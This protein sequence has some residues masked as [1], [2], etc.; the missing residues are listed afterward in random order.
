MLK[1]LFYLFGILAILFVLAEIAGSLILAGYDAGL[2]E[3]R[4]RRTAV[5]DRLEAKRRAEETLG[6][7]YAPHP[8]IGLVKRQLPGQAGLGSDA[9]IESILAHHRP[10]DYNVLLLGGSTAASIQQDGLEYMTRS[11]SALPWVRD[12]NVN[13]FNGSMPQAKQPQQL[14]ALT[15]LLSLGAKVDM[16]IN[17]D[18]FNE[19]ALTPVA[20]P[21]SSLFYPVGW[22]QTTAAD[23]DLQLSLLGKLR[24][25]EEFQERFARFFSVLGALPSRT[26]NALWLVIHDRSE[27]NAQEVLRK[28]SEARRATEDAD[29]V[30]YRPDVEGE[31]ITRVLADHWAR[32]SKLMADFALSQ[33]ILYIHVLQPSAFTP[34]APTR[35]AHGA[36][37]YAVWASRGYRSM[38][39]HADALQRMGVV[40]LDAS[41]LFAPSGYGT[42][43][44]GCCT[45]TD[46]GAQMLIREIVGTLGSLD[47]QEMMA[48]SYEEYLSRFV[49]TTLLPNAGLP[50]LQ[51]GG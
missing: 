45:L 5:M 49:D 40:F 7:E 28:L 21:Y 29:T 37:P 4:A 2:D 11:L 30:G 32:S 15:Y 12:R 51:E 41:A 8:Y 38:V 36:S 18:G 44:Q 22:S 47:G 17:I 16:V 14:Q 48:H 13:V 3:V 42:Y 33:G 9:W 35:A 39:D 23:S 26:V 27:K 10:G 34:G 46:E 43:M 19:V 6:G 25:A 31:D 1:R 50:E 20:D 24:V